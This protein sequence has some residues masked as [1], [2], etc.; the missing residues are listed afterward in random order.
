MGSL[1][2]ALIAK[3]RLRPRN[4]FEFSTH[5]QMSSPRWRLRFHAQ[6]ISIGNQKIAAATLAPHMAN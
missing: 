6:N 1:K 5:H 4:I 2:L 3:T